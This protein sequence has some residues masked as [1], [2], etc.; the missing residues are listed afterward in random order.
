MDKRRQLARSLDGVL[1]DLH[2]PIRLPG[3]SPLNRVGLR[4]FE[5][6]LAAL[7]ARLGDFDRPVTE[8]GLRLVQEFVSNGGSP[9]YDR[10]QA[11]AVPGTVVALLKALEPR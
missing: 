10:A 1:R 4:D 8:N 6:E 9:L 5:P 2:G 7:A 3:A 11:R